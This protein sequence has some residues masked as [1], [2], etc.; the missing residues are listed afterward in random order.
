M[1]GSRFQYHSTLAPNPT[2]TMKKTLTLLTALATAL[3][4]NA[5]VTTVVLEPA[6]LAGAYESVFA[7]QNANGWALTPD[8]SYPAAPVIDTLALAYDGTPTADSLCC[9]AV[10]NG[11]EVAGRIAVIY[12]GSCN[13]SLKA[14]NCQQAGAVAVT[15]S[16]TTRRQ[17]QRPS[18]QAP[19]RNW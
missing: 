19:M 9:E 14:Y 10:V 16:S 3:S 4:M 7:L 1:R 11:N 15:S 18:A 13:Y 6:P 2:D 17:C 8:L 12:R 5:Q